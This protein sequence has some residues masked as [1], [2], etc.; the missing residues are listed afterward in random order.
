MTRSPTP[1]ASVVVVNYNGKEHLAECLT[2]LCADAASLP[3][4]ILVVDNASTDDSASIADE[5]AARYP[6]IQSLRSPLNRGYAGGVNFALPHAKGRYIAVLNPDVVAAPGWLTHLTQFLETHPN[7]G[8]VNPLILLYGGDEERINAAGQK[9]NLTGLGFNYWLGQPRARAG[10]RPLRV[11]GIQGSAFVIRTSALVEM[12]GWDES[13]FLYQEDIALSWLLQTMGYDLCCVPE[14][15]VRHKYHLT[16]YPEKFFL[17]ER[18]RLAMLITNLKKRTLILLSPL[19]AF[20][21]LMMWGYCFLRGPDFVR[22]KIACYFWVARRWARL[23]ARK[24]RI[25]SIRRRNDLQLLNRFS[26][27][28]AWDQFV[29]LGRERG[30]SKR[31]PQGGLPVEIRP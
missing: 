19:L 22:A 13:G 2:A 12:D 15:V 18:N 14:A 1:V 30:E 27:G 28:Y 7:V 24:Q 5:Y 26:L 9:L 21:E 17:L 11:N 29:I 10:R 20:T 6:F 8:A 4:E 31:K 3:F 16:M 25:Q 23:Q